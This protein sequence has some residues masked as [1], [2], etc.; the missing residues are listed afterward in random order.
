M[1][2]NSEI[3]DI[4]EESEEPNSDSDIFNEIEEEIETIELSIVDNILDD[5]PMFDNGLF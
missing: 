4:L 2:S 5:P 3:D 1:K